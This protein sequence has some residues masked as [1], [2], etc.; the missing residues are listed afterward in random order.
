MAWALALVVAIGVGLPVA[1]WSITRR[2]P[3]PNTARWAGR[4]YDAIDRW[5]ADRYQLAW[6]ERSRVRTAV[7]GGRQV[8]EPQLAP[9]AHGLAAQVLAGGFRVLR[10][11]RVLGWADL[12]LGIGLGAAG[13]AWLIT[14]GH[15]EG[16]AAPRAR[17]GQRRA[18]AV[19]GR[20]ARVAGATADPAQR[21]PGPAGQPGRGLVHDRRGSGAQPARELVACAERTLAAPGARIELH[22]EFSWPR[23]EWPRPG[24][25]RG[26]VLRVAAKGGK[27][28]VSTGWKLATRRLETT[29][30]QEFGHL[31]GEGVA[32][33]ARG[34]Y[35]VDFGSFAELHAG[36]R[37]T[38]GGRAAP[39]R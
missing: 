36:A 2:L 11:S 8:E 15:P 6:L 16:G 4:G 21:G 31:I 34:R 29:R 19:R 20:V 32:E 35:M 9:A 7:F 38:A 30:G 17:C 14:S 26:K 27:L 5:L 1:A 18:A 23:A 25:W 12:G 33:P 13:V 10:W 3:P 22:R 24:D 37:P 28:L 39:C